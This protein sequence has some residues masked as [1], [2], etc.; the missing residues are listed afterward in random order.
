MNWQLLKAGAA[1]Q[2][3][4]AQ[5][6]EPGI[7]VRQKPNQVSNHMIPCDNPHSL[8]TTK[9]PYLRVIQLVR[10]T[11]SPSEAQ[12]CVARRLDQRCVATRA[13][14]SYSIVPVAPKVQVPEGPVVV[15]L[16]T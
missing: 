16:R 2:F 8:W 9:N 10:E 13:A 12:I 1:Q 3:E 11:R 7:Q 4:E 15:A 5:E 14:L 6:S